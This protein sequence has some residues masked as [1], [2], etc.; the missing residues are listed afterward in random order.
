MCTGRATSC[1]NT[2][3]QHIAVTNHFVYWRI[4]VKIYVSATELCRRNKS[5]KFCL[6]WFSA[7]CCCHKLLLPRQRFSQKFSSTHKAICRCD[8]LLWHVAATCRQVCTRPL[9]VFKAV[10][11]TQK[12]E[13]LKQGSN[14][15]GDWTRDLT[16]RRTHTSQLGHSCSCLQQFY[17][18]WFMQTLDL[19]CK[20]FLRTKSTSELSCIRIKVIWCIVFDKLNK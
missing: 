16:Y 6:I 5:Q 15:N 20:E 10:K 2:L 17:H 8:V 14:V 9:R 7:T 3:W 13:K 19:F 11:A 1:C 18:P 12:G 4:F